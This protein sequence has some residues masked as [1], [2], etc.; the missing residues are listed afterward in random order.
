MKTYK[1]I[2]TE[3]GQNN[4]I[5]ATTKAPGQYKNMDKEQFENTLKNYT[6]QSFIIEEM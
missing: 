1:A 4:Q 5:I 2:S 3:K 6:W